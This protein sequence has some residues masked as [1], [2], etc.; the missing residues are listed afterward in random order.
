MIHNQQTFVI[1]KP[2][3]VSR[4][5]IGEII[6]RFEKRNLK[7]VAL[8][9]FMAKREDLL[10]QYPPTEKT[11]LRFGE[12]AFKSYSEFG[13]YNLEEDFNTSDLSE[14]GKQVHAFL[15]DFLLSAP[16][17]KMVVAGPHAIEMVRKIVGTTLPL[18]ADMGTI[19]GDFSCDSTAIANHEKR[20]LYNVVHASE[21]E[22]EAEAEI[23]KYFGGKTFSY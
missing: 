15:L 21:N 16:L 6:S 20:P 17:V 5:L 11:F 4:N 13:V 1:I 3:G 10:V 14:I 7:I 23:K 8:E 18:K 12:K 19:R 22:E 2:D 9:M